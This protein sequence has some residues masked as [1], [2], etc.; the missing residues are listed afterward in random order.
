LKQ[1]CWPK[2]KR[3]WYWFFFGMFLLPAVLYSVRLLLGWGITVNGVPVDPSFRIATT[4]VF[5]LLAGYFYWLLAST[6]KLSSS[7]KS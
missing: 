7:R 6:E 5:V 2:N 4:L 1:M 3:E